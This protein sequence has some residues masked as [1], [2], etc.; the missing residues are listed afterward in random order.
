MDLPAP[1]LTAGRKAATKLTIR[2]MWTIPQPDT[3]AGVDRGRRHG[4]GGA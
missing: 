4:G 3:G 2:F 1:R